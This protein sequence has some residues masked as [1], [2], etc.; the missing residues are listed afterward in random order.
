MGIFDVFTGAAAKKAAAANRQL[1]GD[2]RD[3]SIG[4]L[5]TGYQA[6][7]GYLGDA[8]AN[9]QPLTALAG[10]FTRGAGAYGDAS[11]ANGAQGLDRARALF[12]QTPGYQEGLGYG[13]DAIDRR[14][15]SRGMLG[16]GNTNLDTLKFAN[17]YASQKYGDY[18]AGL[19]PYNGAALGA[20][21]AAA[22]GQAGVNTGLAGLAQSDATNRTN[23]FGN[24]T[25][26]MTKTNTDEANALTAASGNLFNFAGNLLKLGTG[27]FGGK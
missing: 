1:Y 24:F 6:G 11:G 9:F 2:Y 12:T 10:D 26:G 4:A 16:S 13:L 17:D 20:T 23:V 5:D 27:F 22:T 18:L 14:A 15:A 7:T 8:L 21:T 19:A 25:S 3:D